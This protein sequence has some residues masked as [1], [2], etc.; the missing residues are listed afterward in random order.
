M[1]HGFQSLECIE[2]HYS[3]RRSQ[4]FSVSDPDSISAK[5]SCSQQWR[6]VWQRSVWLG[7]RKHTSNP[8]L[9]S[10][11]SPQPIWGELTNRSSACEQHFSPPTVSSKL[12]IGSTTLQR[13]NTSDAH[14]LSCFC[15]LISHLQVHLGIFLFSQCQKKKKK[16]IIAAAKQ[17]HQ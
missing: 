13:C 14:T 17:T 6:D 9:Y 5:I 8:R 4:V 11:F 7:E 2:D 3:L 12:E 1:K 10:F 16:T 15:S